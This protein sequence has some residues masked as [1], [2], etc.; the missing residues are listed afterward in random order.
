M[1]GLLST[2]PKQAVPMMIDAMEDHQSIML[3]GPPGSAKSDIAR[4][5]AK[6]AFDGNICDIRLATTPPEDFHL[7][8][9]NMEDRVIDWFPTRM[10]PNE[11]RDG[12]KGVLLLDELTSAP[13]A[14][15]TLGYQVCLDRRCGDTPIPNGWGIMAA[16]NRMGDRGVVYTMPAPLANRFIHFEFNPL[17][18][19][20]SE[21]W[22]NDYTEYCT[23]SDANPIVTAYIR[24][25]PDS[26]YQPP[27][28]GEVAFPT[29]RSWSMLARAV[30]R[31]EKRGELLAP[32]IAVGTVGNVKAQ[33][34]MA[35]LKHK[36]EVPTFAEIVADPTHA[37]CPSVKNL[38]ACFFVVGMLC[39]NM[40]GANFAQCSKYLERLPNEI[41]AA[42]VGMM[43]QETRAAVLMTQ[44][45]QRWIVRVQHL[46]A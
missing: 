8:V 23:E 11:K 37:R 45:G 34:F 27:Q 41:D 15:A 46:L 2:T 39:H 7:P 40:T 26:L 38:G 24:F 33:A 28:P 1:T 16:G 3:W 17:D 20:V 12:K 9:P 31:S 10:L 42:A 35:F 44:A 43:K 6:L 5:I 4:M 32:E 19:R 25:A 21:Q 29:L 36:E 13:P 30:D 14:S 22:V 18:P